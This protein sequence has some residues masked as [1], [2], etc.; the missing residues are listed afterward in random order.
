MSRPGDWE[1]NRQTVER[2]R[3]RQGDRCWW[4]GEPFDEYDTVV[5]HHEKSVKEGMATGAL[6]E[7]MSALDNC[8]AVHANSPFEDSRYEDRES[9]ACHWEMHGYGRWREVDP[10]PTRAA[11]YEARETRVEESPRDREPE[12][13]DVSLRSIEESARECKAEPSPNPQTSPS[14]DTSGPDRDGPDGPGG[15]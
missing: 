2:A 1:F 15:R 9:R 14:I 10:D 8:R 7:E 3:E 12:A 6:A 11:L 13:R 4:C 5:G